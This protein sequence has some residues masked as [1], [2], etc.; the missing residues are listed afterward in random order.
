MS[1]GDALDRF[2]RGL[3]SQLRVMVRSRFPHSLE[4]AESI[5]L[6]IEAAMNDGEYAMSYATNTPAPNPPS[7]RS[8]PTIHA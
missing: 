5:A 8:Q 4:S 3:K 7:T 1:S 6:A 2:V